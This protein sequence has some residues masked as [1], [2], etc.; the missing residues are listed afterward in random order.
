MVL[1]FV[2][3]I[4]ILQLL[5]ALS[6]Q[7]LLVNISI[8]I[9]IDT[10]TSNCIGINIRFSIGIIINISIR[11][12]I[13]VRSHF[14]SR[15]L[16]RDAAQGRHPHPQ[17]QAPRPQSARSPQRIAVCVGG[18]LRRG[19]CCGARRRDSCLTSITAARRQRCPS[20]RARRM[21]RSSSVALPRGAASGSSAIG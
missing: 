20:V 9:H 19:Y 12:R 15:R 5:R 8:G 6:L 1:I 17:P 10:S 21:T 14:G 18:A 4:P 11:I 16:G 7:L 13:S 3:L 2:V